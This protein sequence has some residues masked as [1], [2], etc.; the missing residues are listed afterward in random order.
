MRKWVLILGGLV[1]LALGGAT[2]Y[3]WVGYSQAQNSLTRA[4]LDVRDVGENI[5]RHPE[6]VARLK[7]LYREAELHV[8]AVARFHSFWVGETEISAL[9]TALEKDGHDIDRLAG[10]ANR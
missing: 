1:A 6:D 3:A 7:E 5:V 10:A 4:R 2:V 8:D 9:R